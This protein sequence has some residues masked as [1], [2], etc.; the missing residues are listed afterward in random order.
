MR[1]HLMMQARNHFLILTGRQ[2][3]DGRHN[4]ADAPNPAMMPRFHISHPW[5]RAGDLRR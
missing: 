5:R 3:S 2:R 1:R 4:K